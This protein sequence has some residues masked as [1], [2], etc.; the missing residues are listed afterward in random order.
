MMLRVVSALVVAGVLLLSGCGAPGAGKTTGSPVVSPVSSTTTQSQVVDSVVMSDAFGGYS[1][2]LPQGT[3]RQGTSTGRWGEVRTTYE[4]PAGEVI[5]T[6]DFSP[7][8]GWSELS[9]ELTTTCPD[10]SEGAQQPIRWA[11]STQGGYTG[12]DRSACGR[13]DIVTFVDFDEAAAVIYDADG[14]TP[15]A[16]IVAAHE[17]AKSG[18]AGDALRFLIDHRNDR[19]VD[20]DRW[21]TACETVFGS[22]D[23]IAAAF[24][25][26]AKLSGQVYGDGGPSCEYGPLWFGLSDLDDAEPPGR[27]GW[28]EFGSDGCRFQDVALYFHECREG[29]LV[30]HAGLRRAPTANDRA[31]LARL[32]KDARDKVASSS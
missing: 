5:T 11:G 31:Q 23:A 28:G 7:D 3:L 21:A 27:N 25:T 16:W 1:L 12:W 30:V 13:S 29:D 4:T 24:V 15:P 9:E 8:F 6:I 18:V 2:Q 14:L 26:D 22:A 10:A 20:L 32:V 19:R 17:N